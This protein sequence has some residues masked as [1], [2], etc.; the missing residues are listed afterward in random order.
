MSS[1]NFANTI[2]ELRKRKG[3]S[4]KV[5]AK[6]LGVS[7]ALLS[8]YEN[9]IRECG[10]DFVLRVANYYG[11]SCDYL[12]GNSNSAVRFDVVEKIKEIPEDQ[13]MSIN[14]LYRASAVL[15]AK[16]FKD[17]SNS[18]KMQN[19]Y[20]IAAYLLLLKGVESGYVPPNWI[21]PTRLNKT[22]IKF[23]YM[24][25]YSMLEQFDKNPKPLKPQEVP[26][27][28]ETVTKWTNEFLNENL[29]ELIL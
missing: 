18:E 15:G 12:L 26:T 14:T 13:E 7:Q 6:E 19:V 10:L 16:F 8:H 24:I 22:Q 29:A 25:S 4:Q 20:A 1:T 27:C 3:V 11:V 28:V 21:G 9:G 23:L 17:N 5:A 2:T